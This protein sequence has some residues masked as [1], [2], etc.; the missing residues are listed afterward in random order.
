MKLKI[1]HKVYNLKVN[2]NVGCGNLPNFGDFVNC[3][4][5]VNETI[6]RHYK[7]LDAKRTPNF[8]K[9][10]AQHLPFKDNCFEMAYSS[11]VLEHVKNPY[12][13]LRE[14]IRV[15]RNRIELLIPNWIS[16]REP[17]H[18][19]YFSKKWVL[20]TLRSMGVYHVA[21]RYEFKPLRKFFPFPMPLEMSVTVIL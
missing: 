17:E 12:K 6:H 21:C 11:N 15:A 3:D 13:M 5:Y 7:T 9:C 2:L 4:L 19:H 16:G 14:M 20:K 1:L 8:V 10:D 18:S